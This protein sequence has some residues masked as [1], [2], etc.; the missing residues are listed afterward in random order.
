MKY[1][2]PFRRCQVLYL[3]FVIPYFRGEIE[4]GVGVQELNMVVRGLSTEY[5]VN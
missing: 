3:Y 5:K 2:V 1:D 4:V